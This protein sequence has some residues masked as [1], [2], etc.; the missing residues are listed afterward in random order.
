MSKSPFFKGSASSP[1]DSFATPPGA[2]KG[3]G[4]GVT[5]SNNGVEIVVINVET[6]IGG[7]GMCG[8]RIGKGNKRMCIKEDCK[9]ASHMENKV[10]IT[11]LCSGDWVFVRS[12]KEAVFVEP[13]IASQL[14][15]PNLERLLKDKREVEEWATLFKYYENLES[16]G[17][18]DQ[19]REETKAFE[20]R[21]GKESE[22]HF[23][24]TP[25][26]RRVKMEIKKSPLA[27]QFEKLDLGITA[28][29]PKE[30]GFSDFFRQ[31][32]K[33]LSQ[34]IENLEA[35]LGRVK[36]GMQELSQGT[37]DELGNIDVALFKMG[38]ILGSRDTS[39]FGT[40]TVFELLQEAFTEIEEITRGLGGN[41]QRGAKLPTES[42]TRGVLGITDNTEIVTIQK[43]AQHLDFVLEMA[44]DWSSSG[45]QQGGD[46]L[47][48]TIR[49]IQA[50]IGRMEQAIL[51]GAGT[52][53]KPATSQRSGLFQPRF[54]QT[55]P[56]GPSI[57]TQGGTSFS[58]GTM[59][60]ANVSPQDLGAQIQQLLARADAQEKEMEVLRSDLRAANT[61]IKQ[62]DDNAKTTAVY[63]NGDCFPSFGYAGGWLDVKVTDPSGYA[64]FV[65]PHS[66]LQMIVDG[67]ANTSNEMK[68]RTEAAKLGM[69][70]LF[71]PSQL[72][73]FR[74][75]LP[76]IFGNS[77]AA[78]LL[79]DD[80]RVLP[81]VASFDKWGDVGSYDGASRG[82]KTLARDMETTLKEQAIHHLSGDALTLA[83]HVIGRT[84]SFLDSLAKWMSDEYQ[85]M[86]KRGTSKESA[87]LLTSQLVRA[88]FNEL[89]F[90]RRSGRM[91]DLQPGA[92]LHK[93][94]IFWGNL[95]G[96]Y[97]MEKFN[98]NEFS[99]DLVMSAS[100][101]IFLRNN[102]LLRSDKSEL[103]TAIA[104]TTKLARNAQ[105]T[106]DKAESKAQ[107]CWGKIK[108]K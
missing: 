43:L 29:L 35:S 39:I 15:Q 20:K 100:L 42:E 78:S 2:G 33:T 62:L 53:A 68:L 25:F 83:Q 107:Q 48:E 45:G 27:E 5:L 61:R 38:S 51:K 21:L 87:W 95:Q 69:S 60:V 31:E 99:K 36:D 47:K 8:G 75:A 16:Q 64:F 24:K 101:F 98:Q 54:G 49:V 52:T 34:V 106:A 108:D 102:A 23:G 97:R 6:E 93:H 46:V 77:T 79:A 105:T 96:F 30:D 40:S 66:M 17:N 73:S 59:N 84:S 4:G 70:S 85:I 65:D 9:V 104:A 71:E 89:H 41:T 13:S 63:I 44:N 11:D 72:N 12:G 14:L 37:Q 82:L 81:A 22:N 88:M 91:V 50:D 55:A 56:A 67:C 26:K 18:P 103:E 19:L 86:T 90:V 57:K 32:W 76:P 1:L 92:S 58:A 28:D 94:A 7:I 3:P 10:P 80:S 74:H